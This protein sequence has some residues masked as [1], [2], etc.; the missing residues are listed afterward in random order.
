M[1]DPRWS[2]PDMLGYSN[3][4][5]Y[6][7]PFNSST[8]NVGFLAVPELLLYPAHFR[9]TSL[10]VPLPRMGLFPQSFLQKFTNN[11]SF[12]SKQFSPV[13]HCV[14]MR[15]KPLNH[16]AQIYCHQTLKRV[17]NEYVNMCGLCLPSSPLQG[18]LLHAPQFDVE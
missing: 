13:V 17:Q 7:S 2:G 10:N 11:P 14:G 16:E 3:Q 18:S 9:A 8:Y 12:K 4:V 1:R 6:N 5:P 15:P